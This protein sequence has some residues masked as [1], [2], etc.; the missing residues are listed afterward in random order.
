MYLYY[1]VKDP[2]TSLIGASDIII[3]VIE[4]HCHTRV[5]T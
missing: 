5:G 4:L 2:H 1:M 3:T